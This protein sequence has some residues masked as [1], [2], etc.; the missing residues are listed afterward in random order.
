MRIISSL[1]VIFALFQARIVLT[2]KPG[3][4]ITYR[5]TTANKQYVFI[6]I[7]PDSLE[8]ELK[9]WNDETKNE[10][11]AIRTMYAKSGLYKNDGSKE[12]LWTVDWYRRNVVAASDGIHMVTFGYSSSTNA[13]KTQAISKEE[14]Q[15]EAVSL[16]ANGKLL[17]RYAIADLVDRPDQLPRSVSHFQW[18]EK[19]N[20][21]DGQHQFEVVTCDNNRILFD[22]KTGNIAK[23]EPIKTGKLQ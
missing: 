10:I 2:E 9:R 3:P 16:F 13:G 20:M 6:M 7:A 8:T 14:L 22:L 12:P 19:S 18:L 11:R 1:T 15:Q 17:K 23:K 21:L 4:P 5:E